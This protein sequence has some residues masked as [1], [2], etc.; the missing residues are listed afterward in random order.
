M[1]A[2]TDSINCWQNDNEEL[3]DL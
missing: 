2:V 3:Q 1:C